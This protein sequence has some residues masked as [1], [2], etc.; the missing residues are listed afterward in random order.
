MSYHLTSTII[1]YSNSNNSCCFALNQANVQSNSPDVRTQLIYVWIFPW[2]PDRVTPPPF[3][4]IYYYVYNKFSRRIK[5]IELRAGCAWGSFVWCN[6]T[7]QSQHINLRALVRC[8]LWNVHHAFCSTLSEISTL[9]YYTTV[10]SDQVI[11]NG[12]RWMNPLHLK[13]DYSS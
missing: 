13:E 8:R 3:A 7:L 11:K 2:S 9:L 5:K 12:F 1:P 4:F 10:F 6:R